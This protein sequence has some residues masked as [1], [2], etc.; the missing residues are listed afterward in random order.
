MRW[1]PY[2]S[3][4][5]RPFGLHLSDHA[6]ALLRLSDDRR[7]VAIARREIPDGIIERGVVRDR[8]KL[9]AELRALFAEA[10]PKPVSLEKELPVIFSIPESESFT[11]IFT[12]PSA[13]S[14]QAY[15]EAVRTKAAHLIPVDIDTLYWDWSVVSHNVGAMDRVFFAAARKEVIDGYIAVCTE[16]NLVPVAIDMETVALARAFL[17]SPARAG[18]SDEGAVVIA[19]I[20]RRLTTLGFFDG[21]ESPALSLVVPVAGEA[22][23]ASL[24][25]H[26][27]LSEAEAEEHKRVI[28]IEQG[29]RDD[30]TVVVLQE[31]VQELLQEYNK[32]S[33]Y[34][35][36]VYAR[37][38]RSL[39]LAGGSSL[40]PGLIAYLSVNMRHAVTPGDPFTNLSSNDPMHAEL[41]TPTLFAP[42]IG[43]A[44]HALLPHPEEGINLLHGWEG[45]RWEAREHSILRR[46]RKLALPIFV[47]SMVLLVIIATFY[48]ILP[49]RKVMTANIS[50]IAPVP[51]E[52]TSPPAPSES[53][54][55][56]SDTLSAST[57]GERIAMATPPSLSDIPESIATTSVGTDTATRIRI[58]ETPTG[59]LNVRSGPGTSF[60]IVTRITPGEEFVVL[61]ERDE[62]LK[63]ELPTLSSGWVTR[64]YA[65]STHE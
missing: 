43:L 44:L 50:R 51:V 21:L 41:H 12:I 23:T 2:S 29:H 33:S 8:A 40:L 1:F 54:A 26:L 28:G 31:R 34:F 22:F 13:T 25:K 42:V 36:S 30:K 37:P 6:I 18:A 17:P 56:S 5:V 4:L 59:W 24:V 58:M 47:A 3:F 16:C 19:D 45:E 53:V 10:R 60:A 35:T 7:I 49:Y 55:S 61:E 15:A 62:W 39:L 38:V 48:I 64:Q 52:R 20:G 14:K 46:W 27:T 65:T 57:S 63:L 11:H 32:A 9:V